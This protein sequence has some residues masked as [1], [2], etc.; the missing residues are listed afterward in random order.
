M[1][2]GPAV[3]CYK[4]SYSLWY[5]WH[6]DYIVSYDI[7]GILYSPGS[8]NTVSLDGDIESCS[9]PLPFFFLYLQ[10]LDLCILDMSCRQF[11]SSVLAASAVYLSSEKGRTHLRTITGEFVQNFCFT[12]RQKCPH[13]GTVL[14][15]CEANCVRN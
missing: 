2:C 13:M 15:P 8:D 10:L 7:L 4:Y 11:S 5:H 1:K 12:V 6:P 9:P 3:T 14:I